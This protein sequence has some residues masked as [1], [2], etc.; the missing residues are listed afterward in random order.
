MNSE[1]MSRVQ[2]QGLGHAGITKR[3][4]A[5]LWIF[6]SIFYVFLVILLLIEAQGPEGK[7]WVH[8]IS[9]TLLMGLITVLGIRFGSVSYRRGRLDLL[10][11]PVWYSLWTLLGLTSFGFFGLLNRKYLHPAVGDMSWLPQG[12]WLP[13]LGLFGLWIGYKLG[14][15]LPASV[16]SHSVPRRNKAWLEPNFV[17]VWLLYGIICIER[18]WRISIMG[19]AYGADITALG[20]LSDLNQWFNYLEQA[21]LLVIAIVAL[22]VFRGRWAKRSLWIMVGL[23]LFFIFLSG[24]MKQLLWLGLVLYGA[25]RYGRYRL[26]IRWSIIAAIIAIFAILVPIVE[27]YRPL[28]SAGVV[29]TRS[30]R[31]L[32]SGLGQALKLSWGQ[33]IG[34]A[35][36][37]LTNKIICRQAVVAETWGIILHTTPN[38][39]PYWGVDR[40]LMIP[41]Y[42]V[43]RALWPSKPMLSLGVDFNIRYLGAPPT[44]HSSAAFT[45]FGDLY[46]SAGWSAVF[47][48]MAIFGIIVALLY[49]HLVVQPLCHG[50]ISL[51]ALYI[52]TLVWIMDPGIGYVGAIVGS[53]QRFV[54]FGVLL[55][56]FHLHLKKTKTIPNSSRGR[57]S[58]ENLYRCSQC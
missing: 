10:E 8:Y 43:P 18:L 21:S 37:M 53:I 46:L 58:H 16:H 38:I 6:F 32:I 7:A 42:V 22:Q 29:N 39:I 41:A 55:Y 4:P 3:S 23:E 24:F 47:V 11:L 40:L 26:R 15:V 20:E 31:S 5:G 30:L 56:L 45:L 50:R 1:G 51:T 34:N 54:F 25:M 35:F 27:A 28:I 9:L 48:G 17:F 2:K 19:V 13:I 44:T 57:G 14:W 52:G 36:Q 12:L 33:G 49:R